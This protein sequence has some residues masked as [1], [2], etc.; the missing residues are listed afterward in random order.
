MASAAAAAAGGTTSK[1]LDPPG[2]KLTKKQLLYGFAYADAKH[3]FEG[4]AVKMVERLGKEDALGI[5][6]PGNDAGIK[7]EEDTLTSLFKFED[8]LGDTFPN[9]EDTYKFTVN[10]PD[11]EIHKYNVKTKVVFK[12]IPGKARSVESDQTD[13]YDWLDVAGNNEIAFAIDAQFTPFYEYFQEGTAAEK[14]TGD[15]VAGRKIHYLKTRE[16]FSDPSPQVT[17]EPYDNNGITL[18]INDKDYKDQTTITYPSTKLTDTNANQL[19]SNFTFNLL[20]IAKVNVHGKEIPSLDVQIVDDIA[21]HTVNIVKGNAENK[22]VNSINALVD[23]IVDIFKNIISPALRNKMAIP[24]KTGLQSYFQRKRAGDWLQVLSCTTPERFGLNSNIRPFLVTHDRI[25]LAY[26]LLMG[27]DV[28]YTLK[29]LDSANPKEYTLLFF[30]KDRGPALTAEDALAAQI[31]STNAY[32]ASFIASITSKDPKPANYKALYDIYKNAYNATIASIYTD[33]DNY[34]KAEAEPAKAAK[35]DNIFTRAIKRFRGTDGQNIEKTVRMYLYLYAKLGI[36]RATIPELSGDPDADV[37]YINGGGGTPEQQRAA[38]T[39]ITQNLSKIQAIINS[40]TSPKVRKAKYQINYNTVGFEAGV[41]EYFNSKFSKLIDVADGKKIYSR[42]VLVLIDKITIFDYSIAEST[43]IAIFSYLNGVLRD[44]EKMGLITVL[45]NQRGK[46]T[47]NST[48]KSK[49][50]TKFD[51]FFAFARFLTGDPAA[52]EEVGGVPGSI[53]LTG[54]RNADSGAA[55]GGGGGAAAAAAPPVDVMGLVAAAEVGQEEDAGEAVTAGEAVADAEAAARRSAVDSALPQV[56]SAAAEAAAAAVETAAAAAASGAFKGLRAKAAAAVEAAVEADE[57]AATA[58]AEAAATAAAAGNEATAA[59]EFEK[60]EGRPLNADSMTNFFPAHAALAARAN[61]DGATGGGGAT[62]GR[63]GGG[64]RGG[65]KKTYAHSPLTTFY[66]LLRDLSFRLSYG[67]PDERYIAF[68]AWI[69]NF[70]KY[71]IETSRVRT[72]SK[73]Y[74]DVLE[75][76]FLEYIQTNTAFDEYTS[77]LSQI[78]LNFKKTYYGFYDVSDV[79]KRSLIIGDFDHDAIY[80]LYLEFTVD[81]YVEKTPFNYSDEPIEKLV[82]AQ[83]VTNQTTLDMI[84]ETLKEHEDLENTEGYKMY[85]LSLEEV[86]KWYSNKYPTQAAALVGKLQSSQINANE[87][88]S[89]IDSSGMVGP[90]RGEKQSR[91]I[92]AVKSRRGGRRSTFKRHV[93][94]QTRGRKYKNKK[95]SRKHRGYKNKYTRK[96][97]RADK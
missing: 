20:P 66:L 90:N 8:T 84:I 28:V 7:E 63:R 16:E 12:K 44:D 45:T 21:K 74:L 19:Y 39:N 41:K 46:L 24:E 56:V 26:G 68:I 76:L 80:K 78:M 18:L 23:A 1:S 97:R 43:G 53:L 61:A 6:N 51:N 85:P 94:K 62:T 88:L 65:G 86:A 89:P 83:I 33:I 59:A 47:N 40:I 72:D 82:E 25:C 34:I 14:E 37:R 87:S 91:F 95:P 92:L 30:Y 55:G 11:A 60:S 42:D 10:P 36:F 67:H 35:P 5:E 4:L 52:V 29:P 3:D 22:H 17:L 31:V 13:L 77:D 2:V 75:V 48:D 57:A 15:P 49:I 96:H 38:I 58:A 81:Q 64:Q 73:S 9:L 71:C 50:K 27:I 54:I 32:I 93:S 79:Y 70:V 69:S